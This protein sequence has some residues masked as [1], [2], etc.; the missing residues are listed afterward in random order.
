MPAPGKEFERQPSVNEIAVKEVESYIEQIEKRSES[1]SSQSPLKPSP[2]VTL[3]PVVYDDM[4]QVVMQSMASQQKP[5]IVLPIDQEEMK[6]G[7]H[8]KV[9]DGLK[10]LAEWSKMMITKYPGRVFYPAKQSV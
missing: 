2:A 8:L 9:W 6:V 10:W 3:P 5:K 4:G 7:L 1:P